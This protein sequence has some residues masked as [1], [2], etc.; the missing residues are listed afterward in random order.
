MLEAYVVCLMGVWGAC[1]GKLSVLWNLWVRLGGVP[2]PV[3]RIHTQLLR[4]MHPVAVS[5]SFSPCF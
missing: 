2:E 3:S 5:L 4:F 1:A